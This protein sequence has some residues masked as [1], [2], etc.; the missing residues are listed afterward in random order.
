MIRFFSTISLAIILAITVRAQSNDSIDLIN[1]STPR[2]YTVEEVK[3]TG[4]QFL[5]PTIL[6][7]MTN[8]VVGQKIQLPG[9]E[10][11]KA[12]RKFWDNGLFSDVKVLA[13]NVHDGKASLNFALKER[14][15]LAR[16][17]ITGVNKSD[18]KD[19]NESLKL[20]PGSQINDNVIND[21]IFV[22][23]KHYIEKGYF[24]V[25]V[26]P[27]QTVDT[28]SN[29]VILTLDVKKNAR[30][31][32]SDI[33]FTGNQAFSDKR[34]R[35]ALKKTHRRDW[36]IFKG[37]KY[38]ESDFKEDKVKL[39]D[40]YNE[41]GY[42]DAKIISD[43]FTIVSPKRIHL[44]INVE[45]G[46]KYY[47]R[48]I[49]WVGNT[50]YPVDALNNTLGIKKGDVFN[51]S[52]LNKRLQEDEDA[53]SSLYLDNGYLFFSVSPTE[54]RIDGDSIDFEMRIYEGKQATLNNVFIS[55]N[56]KTNEHVVR[57][58]LHTLPGEL[59]SKAD[60]IRTVRELA[61]L[62]YFDPEKIE[63]V[64]MPNS[65]DGTVD[66]EYKL[67]ERSN[68]QLEVSGGY[69]SGM[70]VGTLGLKFS[71]FSAR[72]LLKLSAW[73]P[74]PSGDGQTLSIRAQTSGQY[75]KS[76]NFSF[77]EPWLGGK[78]PNS[79]SVSAF[80]SK[81]SYGTSSSVWNYS[82]DQWMTITGGSVGFGKR[83]KNP[84]DYFNIYYDVNYQVYNLHNYTTYFSAENG[85]YNDLSFRMIISRNS[86]SQTI[87]PRYGSSFSFS[88]QLTP[89]Y[90]LVNGK[91]YT[92]TMSDA[93][94]FKWVEYHKWVFKSEYYFSLYEKL[95]LAMKAQFG[96]IGMYQKEVGYSPFQQFDVGGDGMSG[97]VI[98]GTD[99]IPLRGY[100]SG[101]ITPRVE[102]GVVIDNG[103]ENDTKSGNIYDKMTM[104]IRYPITLN[105]SASVYVH[106]F[107]EGGN[108]WYNFDSFN[109]FSLKRSAGFGF[110][111]FLPMFGLL[112]ID[113]GYGFDNIP[114]ISG[115]NHGQFAFTLGQQ[116]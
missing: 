71:N 56:T 9:E 87:Y 66:L 55:G 35:R 77:M 62:G 100:T 60:I 32:I 75:Y 96:Y 31:K 21:A 6:V 50:V 79:L 106:T 12:M 78:K 85:S 63:P 20:R 46:P 102:N 89:P 54:V 82:S 76:F 95:V 25:D 83:L 51:Q 42:R 30:V 69:G 84:D 110:R 112:G 90:S 53:V 57:R 115:A 11:T 80:H 33:T 88:A 39:V 23:K 67:I 3:V 104:E 91:E 19:F 8:I 48:K 105:P 47:F 17:K 49:E 103:T 61:T 15:R 34:L 40:F 74:V 44:Y 64:P 116:F 73:R 114:G 26:T 38:I 86:V 22:I 65:S 18:I 93:D 52:I 16:F 37:S 45:E 99:I 14:P 68:D 7:S 101:S 72:N 70:I 43:S 97:Y 1:Y 94:R 10:V 113:W 109:P 111:A 98:P 27:I 58:E 28:A 41:R 24:Y 13:Y 81:M 5:D 107:V 108:C 29:R 2:E 4:V 36:N 59:F 92:S